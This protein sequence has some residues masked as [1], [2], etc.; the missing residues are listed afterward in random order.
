MGVDP[1]IRVII[2]PPSDPAAKNIERHVLELGGFK[3]ESGVYRAG[4]AILLE[5]EPE[6][7]SLPAEVEE[8]IVASR[9]ESRSGRPCLTVHAPGLPEKMRLPPSSPPT[10]KCLLAEMKRLAEDLDLPHQ[11][12][13][14]ATHHGPCD[15]PVPITFAEIGSSRV[16]WTSDV[17]GEVVARS[18]LSSL[19]PPACRRAI[20]VGGPH[21][22]PLHTRVSLETEVG[23][24][25]ILSSNVQVSEPLVE[26]AVR[27]SSADMI[28]I[29]WKG[30]KREQRETCLRVSER[31][32]VEIVRAGDLLS[33][34]A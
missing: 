3:E 24:G 31:L 13:L 21:Y 10:A 4:R 23:I 30:A 19:R 11:V 25:H 28:V 20:G 29:D 17:L 27:R 1:R 12:S 18:I 6:A 5:G 16:E 32:G 22:S 33:K 2:I 9:H 34:K 7:V 15:F 26:M 14:E 8:V